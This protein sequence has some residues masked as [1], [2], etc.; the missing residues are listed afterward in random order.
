MNI[1]NIEKPTQR[2][3]ARALLVTP[4]SRVLLIQSREP[5]SGQVLWCPPGGGVEVGE[6]LE[7]C[8]CRELYEETGMSALPP[9]RHVWNRQATFTW[10]GERI[11]QQETYYLIHTPWF[12][13][14]MVN[15]PECAET[16]SFLG[17]RWWPAN[18][19]EDSDELFI[20]ENLGRHLN[21]LL[22]RNNSDY[23]IEV[24]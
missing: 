5:E 9:F 14:S 19:I 7:E 3:S 23:P 4:D 24:G 20:P 13:P 21:E 2:H 12:K 22:N 16:D 1:D 18:S 17:F 10:A 15:N 6:T 8:L 11:N